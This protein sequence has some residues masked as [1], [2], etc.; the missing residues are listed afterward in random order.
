MNV[1]TDKRIHL[2]LTWSNG[3]DVLLRQLREHRA[4]SYVNAELIT[5]GAS[6]R[7]WVPSTEHFLR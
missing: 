5:A 2:M 4:V 1:S 3:R 7:V 6:A